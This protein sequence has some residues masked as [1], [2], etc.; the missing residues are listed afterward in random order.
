MRHLTAR[1]HACIRT[2]RALNF[3]RLT[4]EVTQY[5]LHFTLN[6]S[7]ARDL[8]LDRPAGKSSTVVG[9]SKAQTD[10]PAP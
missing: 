2:P 6:G 1:M 9:D 3:N 7:Q 5:L 4:E 8:G 10:Q